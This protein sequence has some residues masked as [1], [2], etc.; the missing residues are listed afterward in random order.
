MEAAATQLWRNKQWHNYNSERRTLKLFVIN[1]VYRSLFLSLISHRSFLFLLLLASVPA[2][3]AT[4]FKLLVPHRV[5]LRELAVRS[6]AET[7]TDGP[8]R[9][10]QCLHLPK[11]DDASSSIRFWTCSSRAAV[12]ALFYQLYLER[13]LQH[14][15]IARV[16]SPEDHGGMPCSHHS[17][18][19][20]TGFRFICACIN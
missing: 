10:M 14:Q 9:D 16:A 13:K 12:F 20:V 18:R 8:G 2:Q 15:L 7:N 5:N 19:V 17:V 11:W 4:W 1:T 6:C 3:E